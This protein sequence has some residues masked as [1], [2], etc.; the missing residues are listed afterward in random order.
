MSKTDFKASLKDDTIDYSAYTANIKRKRPPA[1][2]SRGKYA[3]ETGNDED[4]DYE[5]GDWNPAY[6]RL[7][8]SGQKANGG[9]RSRQRL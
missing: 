6:R 9:R 8:G 7:N 1:R 5:D 4:D 3:R 2:S